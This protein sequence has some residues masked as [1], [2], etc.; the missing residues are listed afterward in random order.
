MCLSWGE[1]HGFWDLKDHRVTLRTGWL[2]N[3]NS[4]SRRRLLG[5]EKGIRESAQDCL[6]ANLQLPL[7]RHFLLRCQVDNW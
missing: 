1:S 7:Y 6:E 4:K 5:L 3:V 2:G